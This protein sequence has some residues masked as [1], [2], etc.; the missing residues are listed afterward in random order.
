[1]LENIFHLKVRRPYYGYSNSK[2]ASCPALL[3]SNTHVSHLWF[4]FSNVARQLVSSYLI[5]FSMAPFQY[6]CLS[7]LSMALDVFENEADFEWWDLPPK[8][9]ER[10]VS[11]SPTLYLLSGMGLG[12][13]KPYQ[14]VVQPEFNRSNFSVYASKDMN[15]IV[16][17]GEKLAE[18]SEWVPVSFP[19]TNKKKGASKDST[20][21]RPAATKRPAAKKR[22]AATKRPAAK[23]RPAATKRPA[24]KK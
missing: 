16:V 13:Y 11:G 24:A 23:K 15:V 22:P 21:K 20:L 6:C 3:M 5:R 12:A 14:R 19:A 8:Q 9:C 1:M 7:S 4:S 18:A 2:R 17:K 10:H